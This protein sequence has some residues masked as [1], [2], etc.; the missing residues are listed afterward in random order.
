[1]GEIGDCELLHHLLTFF[2]ILKCKANLI[3]EDFLALQI[4]FLKEPLPEIKFFKI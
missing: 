3:T 4:K 2:V 1:M